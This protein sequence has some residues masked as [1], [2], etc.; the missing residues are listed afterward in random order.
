M[1]LVDNY[2]GKED[3]DIRPIRAH[4]RADTFNQT[5]VEQFHRH[6]YMH[7]YSPMACSNANLIFFVGAL[8]V[9]IDRQGGLC[10]FQYKISH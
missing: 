9:G 8:V 10:C 3:F 4:M 2:I 5:A 6:D 1:A 7:Y